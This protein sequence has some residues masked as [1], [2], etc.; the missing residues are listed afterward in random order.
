M[1][2]LNTKEN[3]CF[4]PS[5]FGHLSPFSFFHHPLLNVFILKFLLTEGIFLYKFCCF[6]N[7]LYLILDAFIFSFIL[8]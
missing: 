2:T 1:V 3:Q 4:A 7:L 6:K 5:I 8:P